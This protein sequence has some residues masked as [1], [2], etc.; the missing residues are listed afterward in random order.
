M[1]ETLTP[2]L[3]SKAQIQV[4]LLY[5]NEGV[6]SR[7]SAA[8]VKVI[9]VGPVGLFRLILGYQPHILHVHQGLLWSYLIAASFPATVWV[10]HSHS[11]PPTGLTYW[12]RKL[13]HLLLRKKVACV[14]GV[15]QAVTEA[16]REWLADDLKRIKF[17]TVS[18][19]IEIPPLFE[20]TADHLRGPV[21]GMAS[22]LTVDKGV[23]EFIKAIPEIRKQL[24]AASFTLAGDGPLLHDLRKWVADN[25]LEEV[26]HVLGFVDDVASFWRSIDFSLFTSPREAFGLTIIESLAYEKPVIAYEGEGGVKEL[27]SSGSTGIIVPY[28]DSEAIATA[29]R[30][31]WDDP[32]A[33]DKI[34]KIGRR[35]V[36]ENFQLDHVI[37]KWI[38]IYKSLVTG[39]FYSHS[40]GRE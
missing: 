9:S 5:D 33:Y 22:R 36:V 29:C 26:V 39:K 1:V 7:L 35:Y 28:G 40:E 38:L 20:K 23:W 12:K 30:L 21:I 11:Y 25:Q 27:L 32:V 13:M 19:A 6:S 15:G 10:L 34:K 14:V 2:L 31:L 18:N 16:W 24:P 17:T 3:A 8:G 37:D 4:A